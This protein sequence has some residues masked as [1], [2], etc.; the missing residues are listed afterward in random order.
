LAHLPNPYVGP[1]ADV[2]L[3]RCFRLRGGC[4]NWRFEIFGT[5]VPAF[6]HIRDPRRDHR[7]HFCHFL[8]RELGGIS[9]KLRSRQ[10]NNPTRG[11]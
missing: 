10:H 3:L 9:V 5:P 1:A 6:R 11:W 8:L 7:V 4:A 2:H